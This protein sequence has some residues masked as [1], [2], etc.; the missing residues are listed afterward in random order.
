MKG[1]DKLT[2]PPVGVGVQASNGIGSDGQAGTA[3]R[4]L[5]VI[6]S[7]QIQECSACTTSL[8][9]YFL[10]DCL[11]PSAA[12]ASYVLDYFHV[13]IPVCRAP[14]TATSPPFA[15]GLVA[16]IH[17]FPI[18]VVM[19]AQRPWR[20]TYGRIPDVCWRRRWL[21]GHHRRSIQRGLAR[22]QCL[23]G[24]PAARPPGALARLPLLELP[25]RCRLGD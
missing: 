17:R 19:T 2:E 25:V 12:P 24:G 22:R 15:I 13:V 9:F 23:A 16:L 3:M 7:L 20:P 21:R 4:L 5:Q 8:P 10:P 6:A 1:S 11:R 14:A 18:T